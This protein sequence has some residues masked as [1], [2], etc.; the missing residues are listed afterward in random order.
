METF[1]RICSP[2]IAKMKPRKERCVLSILRKGLFRLDYQLVLSKT[3][4]QR[5]A[6][7]KPKVVLLEVTFIESSPTIK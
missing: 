2:N 6:E 7:A 1:S 3:G 4:P 5:V